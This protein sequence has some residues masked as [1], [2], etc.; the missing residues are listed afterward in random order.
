[1]NDKLILKA[2]HDKKELAIIYSVPISSIVWVGDNRYIVIKNN[3]Q[4]KV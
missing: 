2:Q 4:I 1:M 3:S